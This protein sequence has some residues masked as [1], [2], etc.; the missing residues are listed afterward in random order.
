MIKCA[1]QNS[2]KILSYLVEG[3]LNHSNGEFTLDEMI[4]KAVSDQEY[5]KRFNREQSV[6]DEQLILINQHILTEY[7]SFFRFGSIDEK[8]LLLESVRNFVISLFFSD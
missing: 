3:K 7:S 1:L 6:S 4:E 2:D 5:I 8:A